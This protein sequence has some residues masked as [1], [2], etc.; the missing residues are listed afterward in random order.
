MSSPEQV[1]EGK[2]GP[3]QTG[4]GP[5]GTGHARPDDEAR[6]R[7]ALALDFDD[8]VEAMRWALRLRPYFGVAKVGLEL[9][10]AA[11]PPVVA[12]LVA[13]GFKVFVDM[14]LADIPTVTGRAARVLGALGASYLTLHTMTGPAG[15]AAGVEGFRAGADRAG[16]PEPVALVV[17]VLTSE[18]EAPEEVLRQRVALAVAAGCGGV[19]CAAPDLV[20]VLGSAPGLLTVVPGIRL[21]G[22]GRHDQ[23]RAA[24]PGEAVRRGAGLLVVGR[25]V[26]QAAVPEEA[27]T[28]V[29]EEVRAAAAGH[30]EG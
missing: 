15:L 20:T 5:T 2:A 6:S 26:T 28:A 21:T 22:S 25:T 1:A 23:H 19:V 16:L 14:K 3:L 9:F 17:T 13:A 11:G 7:L 4:T 27:A 24:S 18:P 10:S 12:E 29:L 8:S 30:E